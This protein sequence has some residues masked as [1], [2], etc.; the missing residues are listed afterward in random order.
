MNDITKEQKKKLDALGKLF[1][2]SDLGPNV[3]M[4]ITVDD[5]QSVLKTIQKFLYKIT[6][7]NNVK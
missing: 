1:F 6:I 4:Y 3:S 2:E 5:E 7:K